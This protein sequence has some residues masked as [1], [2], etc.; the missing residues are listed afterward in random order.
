M[1]R[2]SVPILAALI[3]SG[4]IQQLH[5]ADLPAHHQQAE[6]SCVICGQ[7]DNFDDALFLVCN[8]H[9]LVIHNECMRPRM[10]VDNVNCPRCPQKFSKQNL[11][12]ILTGLTGG[13]VAA[14]EEDQDDVLN[15]EDD[16]LLQAVAES[17][18]LFDQQAAQELQDELDAQVARQIQQD[19]EL[20][21]V[22]GGPAGPLLQ[23]QPVQEQAAQ[24]QVEC[25]VCLGPL[26]HNQDVQALPCAHSFHADCI[27]LWLA[28]HNDC[29]YCREPV[30]QP[31]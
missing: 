26:N 9:L 29:P 21:Q 28:G 11:G 30:N 14:Q 17:L 23:E 10:G 24:A 25:S 19:Y 8:D 15:V 4:G 7:Q 18:M 16:E 27:N 12:F 1:Y 6:L 22:L 20:A 2:K 31:Q 3:I 5:A 13:D